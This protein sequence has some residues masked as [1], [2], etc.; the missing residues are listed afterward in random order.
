MNTSCLIETHYLPSLEYFCTIL[1]FDQLI[2]EKHEHYVKQS[3]RNRCYINTANG[4]E[5]LVIPLAAKHGKIP[6]KDVRI[7]NSKRWQNNHWRALQSAYANTPFFEHYA[8]DLGKIIHSNQRFVYDLNLVL[9]SFCLR[10]LKLNTSISETVS[11]EKYVDKEIY[12]LR[13]VMTPKQHYSGRPF[14]KP[15]PYTR[16]F[17]SA[18]AENLSFVDLLF[19][20]GPSALAILKASKKK[21]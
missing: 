3:F 15:V 8:D 20:E 9:L 4:V 7:D 5:M 13:S 1:D 11:Y 2:I 6:V 17:G 19:C 16:V 10:S 21:I 12:D 18:F 14:Y